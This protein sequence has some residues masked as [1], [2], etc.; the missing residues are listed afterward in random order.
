[1]KLYFFI[2]VQHTGDTDLGQAVQTSAIVGYAPPVWKRAQVQGLKELRQT[3]RGE[4]GSVFCVLWGRFDTSRH[5]A[6][7]TLL[8]R[9]KCFRKDLYKAL[10]ESRTRP[11]VLLVIA[12]SY[13]PCRK[14]HGEKFFQK[15]ILETIFHHIW[16]KAQSMIRR[17]FQLF[18]EACDICNPL[19]VVW[20]GFED[21]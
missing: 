11:I 15:H 8:I 1:M 2:K 17:T 19:S 7:P 14:S 18:F 4:W 12:G 6:Q 5:I 16:I 9:V 13:I 20:K 21:F 10:E 3:I